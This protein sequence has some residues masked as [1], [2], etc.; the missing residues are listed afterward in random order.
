MWLIIFFISISISFA[1]FILRSVLEEPV[2]LFE[3]M[4]DHLEIKKA[5][6]YPIK[7]SE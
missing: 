4:E 7:S 2:V 6:L 1:L 3:N 5:D